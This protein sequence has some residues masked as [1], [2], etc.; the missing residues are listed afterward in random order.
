MTALEDKPTIELRTPEPRQS[1]VQRYAPLAVWVIVIATLILITLRIIGSGYIPGGDARRHVAK[2][3]TDRPYT[4]I[5][6]MRPDYTMDHSPGWEWLL[7]KLHGTAGWDSDALMSFSIF[8][9]MACVLL[10]PLP[11]LKRP[12]AW[13]AALLAQMVAIPELMTRL[14]QARP[15]LLTEGI[16]IALLFAWSKS[17]FENPSRL[18]LVLT[19][20]GIALS[21]WMHGAWY[22]WVLPLGAFF[23]AGWWR[24]GLWLSACWGAGTIAGAVITGKPIE[25]LK[26]AVLIAAAVSRE[27]L[28]QWLLVGEFRPSYGEFATVALVAI[29]WLWRKQQT[30]THADLLAN[31]VFCL[32]LLCW[33]LGFKAD[34]FWADWGVPAVLVWLTLQFQ[35]LM[36]SSWDAN[37]WRR[38]LAGGLIGI[39]LLL[40]STND[41]DRRYS[42][43]LNDIY[44]DARQPALQTWM[45][46]SHGIFYTANMD[47]FY[48]TFYKNPQ[49]DWRYVLGMEPALMTDSDLKIF[50]RI[51]LSNYSVSAFVPWVERMTP[52][53]RL[54]IPCN[55]EPNLPR[56][57]WTNVV[58]NIWIGRLPGH[59]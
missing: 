1:E 46:G 19:C 26:Q 52:A 10:A 17:K 32:A 55:T 16:L 4:D 50:R 31:P 2:A 47:F 14:T 27:H 24:T 5:V 23:L 28:P 41:L 3:F 53:D 37:S 29:V 40:H 57:E 58:A 20:L 22:L 36:A 45:P 56:L 43:S 38:A 25:F 59:H 12:E 39:P 54:E 11:W 13:L 34:R 18:K 15:Y 35:E 8:A 33:I 44:L 42:S 9:T 30:R 49:A 48:N 21:V 6:V 7:Q 51:Q